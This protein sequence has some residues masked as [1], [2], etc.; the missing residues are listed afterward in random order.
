[1]SQTLTLSARGTALTHTGKVRSHNEDAWLCGEKYSQTSSAKPV[2]F[3][4]PSTRPW[5][6]AVA[7]GLGGQNAGE[8]AS[9]QV[10]FFLSQCPDHTPNGVSKILH[11]LNR[12]FFQIG[13]VEPSLAGMGSA[14]AGLCAGPGG[15]FG[16]SV[17][18]A[19]IYRQN[20]SLLE[21]IS[22]DDSVAQLL[23]ETVGE[24]SG[25]IQPQHMHI[26]TQAV[27][28]K[29]EYSPIE[30]HFYPLPVTQPSRFLLCSDGLTTYA[31]FEHI[32]Q[33]IAAEEDTTA[34]TAEL[35]QIAMEAGGKDNITIALLEVSPG[36]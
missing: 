36:L 29:N 18:D 34:A 4:C 23:R 14:V 33:V 32:E 21:Q 7:D 26:L 22:R 27:G 1:M 25:L 3:N 11:Y 35:Y 30:P 2:D 8:K 5:I 19:R 20:G 28:G 31:P 16:F 24:E 15:L 17:G 6:V 9:Q 10:V 12:E 13:E